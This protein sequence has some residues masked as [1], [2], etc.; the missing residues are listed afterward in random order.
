M[1]FKTIFSYFISR[2]QSVTCRWAVPFHPFA[3]ISGPL[4]QLAVKADLVVIQGMFKKQPV[5]QRHPYLGEGQ[6]EDF[7]F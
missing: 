2:F 3:E 6:G 5:E 1:V 7:D 4:T